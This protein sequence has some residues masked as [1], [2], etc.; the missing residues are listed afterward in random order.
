M[1]ARDAT[2][3]FGGAERDPRI[4]VVSGAQ[5]ALRVSDLDS[6]GCAAV[7]LPVAPAGSDLGAPVEVDGT[8]SCPTTAPAG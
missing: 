8:C 4:Y 6:G 5:G 3:R 1:D 2:V 7:T